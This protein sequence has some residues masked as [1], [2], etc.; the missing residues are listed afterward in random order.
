MTASAARPGPP[1]ATAPTR[2][3][4]RS[5]RRALALLAASGL[6]LAGI[7]MLAVAWL[8]VGVRA[9]QASSSDQACLAAAEDDADVRV[10]FELLPAR[11]VCAWDTG[12]GREEV[13]VA[14]SPTGLVVGGLVLVVGGVA[15]TVAALLPPRTPRR[16]G[17]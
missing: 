1:L 3:R 15:G 2:R 16:T 4:T 8:G 6:A 13:V 14:T 9:M 12:A 17:G 5:R 10:R 7:A 11:A